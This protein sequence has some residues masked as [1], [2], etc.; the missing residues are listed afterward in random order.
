MIVA[1]FNQAGGVGKTSLTRDLGFELHERGFKVLLVDGDAQGTLGAF[2][3]EAPHERTAAEMFW[4]AVCSPEPMGT[5]TM[6]RSKYG[7]DLGLA[8]RNLNADE[9]S[10]T[11]QQDPA[12]FLGVTEDLR[13]AYDVVL[14]DCPPKISEITVQILFGADAMLIPVQTEAK[15]VLSFSEVQIEVGKTQ[16]RRR[17]MRLEPIRILGVV[18]TLYNQRLVLHRHHLQEIETK[19]CT[20][21][22]YPTLPPIR[23]YIA[24]SEA[25]THGKPLKSYAPKC[26]VIQDVAAVADALWGTARS[27][28]QEVAN[29]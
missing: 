5:P 11:Q 9:I 24:V 22:G 28:F 15:S 18:P 17:N 23:D 21:L 27:R 20:A 7:P 8:N 25:G 3:G 2:F 16:R 26:P 12:R 1:V 19:L 29:G 14:V 10:L 13:R 4:H 6:H